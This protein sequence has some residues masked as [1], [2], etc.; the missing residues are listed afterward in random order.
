MR[1]FCYRTIFACYDCTKRRQKP[2]NSIVL[3]IKY[4]FLWFIV[5]I[6]HSEEKK[7]KFFFLCFYGFFSNANAL[8]N[9]YWIFVCWLFFNNFSNNTKYKQIKLRP[10]S[11]ERIE[12]WNL[13]N[14]TR[15]KQLCQ[16]LKVLSFTQ[17]IWSG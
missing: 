13:V 8:E 9:I 14:D 6:F 7:I 10:K 2:N 17:Y 15:R 11:I 1:I 4:I 3:Q 12:S 16:L 5:Y